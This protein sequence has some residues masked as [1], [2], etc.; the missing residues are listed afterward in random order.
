MLL[1]L[2][3]IIATIFCLLTYFI[4]VP[5]PMLAKRYLFTAAIILIFGMGWA[6]FYAFRHNEKMIV[7][8][9]TTSWLFLL[10]T[11]AAIPYIETRT[12]APLAALLKPILKPQDEIITYNQYYQDLPFYLERPISVLNWR[13]ELSYG[14][15]HQA[16]HDWIIDDHRFWQQWHSNQRLFVV[17]GLKEYKNFQH[18]Y[19]QEKIFLLGKTTENALM[20]NQEK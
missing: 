19:P 3:L 4:P 11:L 17:M 15:A 7:V 20:S 8:I 9:L 12:V 14:I 18:L 16:T 1:A 10:T 13:N 2:T 6:S 5:N